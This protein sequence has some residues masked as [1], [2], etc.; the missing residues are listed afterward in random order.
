MGINDY[1]R[2]NMIESDGD[3]AGA[4]IDVVYDSDEVSTD[5]EDDYYRND[6]MQ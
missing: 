3:G 2:S 5:Y 4:D 6:T 1:R